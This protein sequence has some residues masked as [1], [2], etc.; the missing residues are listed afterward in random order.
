MTITTITPL[1]RTGQLRIEKTFEVVD[2]IPK[3]A[4]RLKHIYLWPVYTIDLDS[5]AY[6][7]IMTYKY[8]YLGRTRNISDF[9]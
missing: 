6:W 4:I 5:V 8:G 3:D 1:G 2:R 9:I 7:M